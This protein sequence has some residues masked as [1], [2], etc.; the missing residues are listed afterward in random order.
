M[1]IDILTMHPALCEGPL[2]SSIIG[3]AQR[4]GHAIVT[5]HNLHE[6]GIGNYQ[7][8]DDSPYG[9]G[10]GMV[11]RVDVIFKA[12]DSLKNENSK[13]ILLDP[14]GT[15]FKQQSAHDLSTF[16]HLIFICGHYEGVDA[17]IRMHF[18]DYVFSI[19]DYVLTGG[20]LPALVI[21]DSIVRLLPG[22]L[23]NPE[24]ILE[25]SFQH[26]LLEAPV[27]T[28]PRDFNGHLVPDILTSGH[29]KNISLWREEE[30]KL[31]TQR[32]RPDL[33][34]HWLKSQSK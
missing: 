33:W 13:V 7:Q 9:G 14:V 24:S 34:T 15:P 6:F 1:K 12:L 27:Y 32:A 30:S 5:V 17:R 3:R 4:E 20:E 10:A 23:G 18:V 11:L 2:E 29:H 26:G 19:G 8:V 25:E 28:R 22:V 21:I 31:L 16:E